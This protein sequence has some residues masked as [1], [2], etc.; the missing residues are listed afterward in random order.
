MMEQQLVDSKQPFSQR[1][2]CGKGRDLWQ[3]V[4]ALTELLVLLL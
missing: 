4:A 1:P 3:L 2:V